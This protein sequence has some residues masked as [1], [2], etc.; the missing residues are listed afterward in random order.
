MET[1]AEGLQDVAAEPTPSLKETWTV[2]FRKPTFRHIALALCIPITGGSAS[3]R[4]R[5]A[6]ITSVSSISITRRSG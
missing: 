5:W 2:M 3:V 6:P 4:L 1:P